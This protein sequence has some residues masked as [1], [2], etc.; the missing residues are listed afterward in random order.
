MEREGC[1]TTPRLTSVQHTVSLMSRPLLAALTVLAFG[2]CDM[3]TDDPGPVWTRVGTD[4]LYDYAPG[5]DSLHDYTPSY[6]AIPP[7]QHAVRMRVEPAPGW[8]RAELAVTWDAPGFPDPVS[9]FYNELIFPLENEHLDVSPRGLK[10]VVPARCT[11]GIPQ[12]TASWVRV[13][14]TPTDVQELAPCSLDARRR[15]RAVGT[16]TVTTPEGTFEAFVL[17]GPA[18]L[19][20]PFREY[21]A[22][23]AGLLRLD[24]LNEAGVLRG[25]FTRSSLSR[26]R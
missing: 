1:Q 22:W 12:G 16:E 2:G 10:V 18:P 11:G 8:S 23:E 4:A 5:P 17:E 20:G 19:G 21:W 7:R 26:S 24:V 25:R 15:Y 3:L 6:I 13:P 9:P 14:R